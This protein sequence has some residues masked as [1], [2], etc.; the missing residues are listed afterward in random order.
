MLSL[1][2]KVMSVFVTSVHTTQLHVEGIFGMFISPVSLRFV[3]EFNCLVGV[4]K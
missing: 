3:A 4:F 2:Q 1:L